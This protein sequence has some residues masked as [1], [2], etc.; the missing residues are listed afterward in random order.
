MA[1]RNVSVVAGVECC[2][3]MIFSWNV[4][5]EKRVERASCIY[6]IMSDG[7]FLFHV[8]VRLLT[9]WSITDC[10]GFCLLCLFIP[11]TST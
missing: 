11:G 5:P 10:L 8:T 9:G 4:E 2:H 3:G 7:V 1:R 6:K